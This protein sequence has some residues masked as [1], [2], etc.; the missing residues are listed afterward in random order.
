MSEGHGGRFSFWSACLCG[1]AMSALLACR[2][3]KTE[4]WNKDLQA[5]YQ[6]RDRNQLKACLEKGEEMLAAYGKEAPK[7]QE[8]YGS[9]ALAQ[10][11]HQKWDDAVA[12]YERLRKAFANDADIERVCLTSIAETLRD[13]Q[14]WEKSIEAYRN[15]LAKVPG[16]STSSSN[17][18][19]QVGDMYRDQL[20]KPKEALAEYEQVE[21]A[22]PKNARN[23]ALSLAG[24][25]DCQLTLNEFNKSYASYRRMLDQFSKDQDARLL[26]RVKRNA[27]KAI[28]TV[29]DWPEALAFIAQLEEIETDERFRAELG[30]NHAEAQ[31][32]AG[33]KAK[34]RADFV[35]IQAQNPTEA[36]YLYDSQ[37]R[38]VELW[39]EEGNFPEALSAARVLF[40]LSWDEE[41]IVQACAVVA[42]Q[43]KAVDGHLNRANAFLKFQK[44]GPKGEDGNS[45]LANPLMDIPYPSDPERIKVLKAG[46]ESTGDSAIGSRQRALLWILLGQPKDAL[47]EFKMQF[48]RSHEDLLQRASQEWI[49]IGVKAA[50]GHATGLA[51]YYDW[52]NFGSGGRD[53]K[54]QA[55]NPFENLP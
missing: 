55:A 21:K 46:L 44:F 4:D 27:V 1:C 18:R 54:A 2:N 7:A 38:I 20:R 37:S 35:R 50:R 10:R 23:V 36:G 22:D 42:A 3:A 28:A 24:M 11:R 17:A 52:L 12:L 29:K 39:S 41:R 53:G 48:G 25:G 13:A 16:E 49:L 6:A 45:A 51:P 8:I 30:L 31:R 5:L 43:L 26:Q 19:L 32:A 15:L 47:K 33:D 34:A 14:R 9:M 40:D